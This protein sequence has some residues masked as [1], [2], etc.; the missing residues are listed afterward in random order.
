MPPCRKYTAPL[1]WLLPVAH[2]AD[3]PPVM[4]VTDGRDNMDRAETMR[5]WRVQGGD[6][7]FVYYDRITFVK[8]NGT[9]ALR[10]ASYWRNKKLVG[11]AEVALIFK[12]P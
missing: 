8:S 10:A 5:R 2:R 1:N 6:A 12:T 4:P 9:A 7:G 3:K 11:R